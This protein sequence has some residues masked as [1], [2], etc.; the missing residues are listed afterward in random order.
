MK[1]N[2]KISLIVLPLIIAPLLIAGATAA[3]AARNGITQVTTNFLRFKAE[4]LQSYAETQWNLL[5]ENE[6][7]GNPDFVKATQVAVESFAGSL[8]RRDTELIFA[9][10]DDGNVV[11]YSQEFVASPEELDVLKRLI[12]DQVSGWHQFTLQ[13]HK[14]N[15]LEKG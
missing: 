11:L 7:A 12:S 2:V 8:I 4:Q 3:L 14:Y 6:L 1:I 15:T 13:L 10:D 5:I 9:L